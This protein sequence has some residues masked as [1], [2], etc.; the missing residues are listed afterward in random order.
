MRDTSE[1]FE[2][3]LHRRLMER[4]AGE[5]LNMALRM[6][7]TAR[8]VARAAIL[9]E[10]PHLNEVEIA[11][12]LFVRFYGN[13]LPP[14]RVADIIAKIE[15][16]ELGPLYVARRRTAATAPA[17]DAEAGPGPAAAAPGS[18]GRT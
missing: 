14:E 9:R 8:E 1:A 15:R 3:E 17:P 13:D 16:G 12:R 18:A 4:P 6:F 7:T 10:E 2:R 5:R 11:Q